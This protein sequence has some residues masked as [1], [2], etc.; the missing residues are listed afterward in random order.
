MSS[1]RREDLDLGTAMGQGGQGT[2]IPVR[3]RRINQ[4]WDSVYK[5]YS[6]AM[7]PYLNGDALTRMAE[8]IERLPGDDA[9]WLAEKT[10]WPAATVTYGSQITG[11]LMR[12]IP[13]PFRF[14]R[15]DM[16]G[17]GRDQIAELQFLLNADAFITG[18]GLNV[19]PRERLLLLAD[20]A[21]TVSRLHSLDIVVG[22]LSPKNLLFSLGPPP[23]CFFIDCD[24]M[25]L[26][27]QDVLP[28][29]ET[30]GWAV[31]AGESAGTPASDAYK[32]ALLTVRLLAGDQTT[33]DPA[34]I[35]GIDA[36][37]A[38]MARKGLAA[39]R[40]GR[41]APSAWIP[42]LE[43]TA[44]R[45]RTSPPPTAPR[46]QASPSPPRPPGGQPPPPPVPPPAPGGT[47]AGT[48]RN[49]SQNSKVGSA[50]GGAVLLLVI[51]IVAVA[52]AHSG[53]STTPV[54]S[55]TNTGGNTAP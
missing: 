23:S 3:N 43:A 50:V 22:D 40:S 7:R 34:A 25:R 28:Q 17:V 48:K 5:E 55:G 47:P 36:G 12:A 10:A 2:V 11:F 26:R 21:R 52:L 46:P 6:Q 18:I 33:R 53:N 44:R 45:A 38:G 13:A 41:P 31:P 29:A 39:D 15:I 27:G 1:V 35:R 24:A 51:I 19:S 32:F 9:R 54:N 30:P 42:A 8:E 49:Q 4:Q 20:I 16:T 14:R 37:L